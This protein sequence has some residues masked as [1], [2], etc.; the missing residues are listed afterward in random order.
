MI[1][2]EYKIALYKED[3]HGEY[4]IKC[5]G[6]MWDWC[7]PKVGEPFVLRVGEQR[8]IWTSLM[9]HKILEES[10]EFIRFS[11]NHATYRIEILNKG[12]RLHLNYG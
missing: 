10:S 4:Q 8:P 9:V 11:T 3:P 12:H 7:K 5:D 6:V 1:D 2:K